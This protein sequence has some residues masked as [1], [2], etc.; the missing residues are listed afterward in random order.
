MPLPEQP[1]KSRQ[2]DLEVKNLH[3]NKLYGS[4]CW[5]VTKRDVLKFDALDPCLRKLLRINWYRH[6][7]VRWTTGQPRLS[8]IVHARR[9]SLDEAINVAQNRPI[10]RPNRWLCLALC[11]PSGACHT[12]RRCGS[13]CSVSC[14]HLSSAIVMFTTLNIS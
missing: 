6:D 10:W 11:T 1:A 7:E 13:G 14:Q 8:A 4:E 3:F 5:A 2:P 12:R 9:L